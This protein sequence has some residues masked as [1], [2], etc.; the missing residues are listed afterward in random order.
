MDS[1]SVNIISSTLTRNGR[2][3]RNIMIVSWLMLLLCWP[4]NK[5][6]GE[7]FLFMSIAGV[8][9]F[10]A[11][12]W[13]VRFNYIVDK[14]IT[15]GKIVFESNQ[16]VIK[17]T[18][19]NIK[20]FKINE[21]T[22]LKISYSGYEDETFITFVTPYLSNSTGYDNVLSFQLGKTKFSYRFAILNSRLKFL[23]KKQLD[24]YLNRGA[25][26]RITDEHTFVEF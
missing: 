16:L 19:G 1:V 9:L 4:I 8:L 25:D 21:L 15:L 22:N 2:I 12:F 26:I 13:S 3:A 11:F 17:D 5:L 20:Y 23:L 14:Y 7:G 18:S 24:G 6:T 10:N